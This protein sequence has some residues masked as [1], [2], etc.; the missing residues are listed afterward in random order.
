MALG[1]GE[2]GSPL[3]GGEV[4]RINLWL[5]RLKIAH[6]LFLSSVVFALP[7]AV[8]LYYV[9][10]Q[11]NRGIQTCQR[12]VAGTAALAV[13]PGLLR[14]LRE[15]QWRAEMAAA[16]APV[17]P[18]GKQKIRQRIDAAVAALQLNQDEGT[19]VLI[20]RLSSL[21][22]QLEAN[23]AAMTAAQQAALDRQMVETTSQLVPVILDDSALILDSELQTYY[24]MNVTGPLLLQSQAALAETASVARKA[25]AQV[26]PLDARD[27]SQ[28]Q[29]QSGALVNTIFP[30]M[31]YSLETSQRQDLRLQ[32]AGS[33]FSEKRSSPV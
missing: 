30:R 31:R 7:I 19:Q 11:H 33:S 18:R 13:C 28:L 24:L 16:R 32:G 21:W 26:R 9:T 29:A 25:K 15:I 14:D 3:Q 4:E 10:V 12:E 1:W 20:D 23:G 2:L 27:V 5:A 17:S 6:K 8:L 22:K